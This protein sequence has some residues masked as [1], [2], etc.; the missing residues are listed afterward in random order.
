MQPVKRADAA[1]FV[2]HCN[3]KCAGYMHQVSVLLVITTPKLYHNI[4][5]GTKCSKLASPHTN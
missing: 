1:S 4:T 3:S 2:P 5:T